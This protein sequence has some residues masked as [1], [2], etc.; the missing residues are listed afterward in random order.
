M[1]RA[2]KDNSQTE[3]SAV[4][5]ARAFLDYCIE[6]PEQRFWQAIRNFTNH[7]FVYVSE[8]D[9]SQVEGLHDTYYKKSTN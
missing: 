4:E 5:Q 6:H 8:Q 2:E 7:N 1:S 3:G 9:H